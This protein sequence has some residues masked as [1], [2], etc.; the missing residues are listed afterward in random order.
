MDE[1][2]PNHP[3]TAGARDHWHKL[4]AILLH[5]FDLEP[6]VITTS[7]FERFIHDY[8]DHAVLLHDTKDGLHLRIVS[9]AE[10]ERLAGEAGGLPM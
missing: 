9:R 6:V 4:C 1:I 8:P 10:A 5:K 7:D 2:N 3:V